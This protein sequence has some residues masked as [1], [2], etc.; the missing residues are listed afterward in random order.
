MEHC[1]VLKIHVVIAVKIEAFAA[2]AEIATGADKARF[3]IGVVVQIDGAVRIGIAAD[4]TAE[5]V[6]VAFRRFGKL[7]S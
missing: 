7:D 2:S 5:A 1:V 6:T 3:Q 4:R